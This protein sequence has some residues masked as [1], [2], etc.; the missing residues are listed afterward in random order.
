MG[1]KYLIIFVLIPVIWRVINRLIEAAAKK[2]EVERQ[3]ELAQRGQDGREAVTAAPTTISVEHSS[4]LALGGT[5]PSRAQELAARRKAQLEELRRRRAQGM[6]SGGR[7]QTKLGSTTGSGTFPVSA[8]PRSRG[9]G[10]TVTATDLDEW[11]R[12]Q[13]AMKR[14]AE[15]QIQ[16]EELLR[17]R[18]EDEEIRRKAQKD[19]QR[20]LQRQEERKKKTTRLDTH[21]MARVEAQ[22]AYSK[23]T[24]GK[25]SLTD[26]RRRMMDRQSLR[27]LFIMKELLDPPVSMRSEEG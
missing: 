6:P 27:D 22:S 26:I 8:S 24:S 2:K 16:R 21:E 1:S 19:L 15:Q 23:A 18:A 13:A 4:T 17:A 9:K 10:I 25:T 14:K 12:E 3:F 7:I 5:T 11:R 20:Q